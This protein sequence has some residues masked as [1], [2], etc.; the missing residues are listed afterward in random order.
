LPVSR[1]HARCFFTKAIMR[2]VVLSM[3]WCLACLACLV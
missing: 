3:A 2:S 1:G